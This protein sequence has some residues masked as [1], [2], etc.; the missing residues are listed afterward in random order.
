MEKQYIICKPS[1][2]DIERLCELLETLFSFEKEFVPNKE[3][4][5][6]G[7]LHILENSDFGTIFI[8]K[9]DNHI[10]GMLNILYTFSTALG[11]KVAILEDLIIDKEHR[12]KGYGKKLVD[13]ALE[14]C[15]AKGCKRVTLLTDHTNDIAKEF[16]NK[17][18]FEDS[19]MV[20]MRNFL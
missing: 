18:G 20:V 2:N 12:G 13:F 6:K 4:Q 17:M 1:I 3:I 10:V 16:Y 8:V 9:V 5:K 11:S 19:S 14:D 7:L 15:K